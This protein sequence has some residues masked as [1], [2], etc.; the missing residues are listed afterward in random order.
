MNAVQT[1]Y[2]LGLYFLIMSISFSGGR[3]TADAVKLIAGIVLLV[4]ALLSI[5]PLH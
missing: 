3:F 1:E 5:N 4:M 2:L